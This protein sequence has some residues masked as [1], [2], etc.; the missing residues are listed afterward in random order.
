MTDAE[1]N[2]F[3]EQA[4]DEI[5]AKQTQLEAEYNLGHHER[6]VVDYERNSLVF[7]NKEAPVAEATVL[8]VASHVP[9]KK[10]LR[11]SWANKNLPDSVRR[12]AEDVK[13]LYKL[14]GFQLFE[15]E[16]I[17]CDEK[18]AWEITAMACKCLKARGA[19]RVP[20]ANLN[21]YVLITDIKHIG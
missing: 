6:F 12:R 21:A 9:E 18:M 19:Y 17:E 14:T 7:F 3:L 2:E 5:E 13:K 10:N 4:L 11:W 15:R 8:P 1:F 16:S 20:H